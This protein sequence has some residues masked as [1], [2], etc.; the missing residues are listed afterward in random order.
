MGLFGGKKT[1]VASTCYNLA[2]DE[3]TRPD[4]MKSMVVSSVIGSNS[5]DSVADALRTGYLNGPGIKLRSFYRW[6]DDHYN[7]TVGLS[8]SGLSGAPDIDPSVVASAIG[9]TISMQMVRSGP[10][11]YEIWAE[12]WV[13]DNHPE[14]FTDTWSSDFDDTTGQ[15]TVT[16]PDT[17]T[18]SFSPA[19]F[20]KSAYYIYAAYNAVTT[21]TAGPVVTGPLIT[22]AP[23]DPFPSTTGWTVDVS[24]PSHSIYSKLGPVLTDGAGRLYQV[25]SVMSQNDDGTTR[26]HQTSTQEIDTR[27]WSPL[28]IFIYRVGSGNWS[29]DAQV[30]VTSAVGGFF[31]AIPVRLDNKFVSS[32]Y[33]P[34]QYEAAQKAYKKLTGGGKFDDLITKLQDNS[35]LGDID[36]AYVVPGVSL[37]VKDNSGRK[38]LY[39]FFLNA[40]STSAYGESDYSSWA[41]GVGSAASGMDAWK[42]W[43]DDQG[44]GGPLDGTPEPTRPSYGSAARNEIRV[45]L[46][47]TSLGYDTR[48]SWKSIKQETGS[49]LGK[50]GAKVGDVWLQKGG[51]FAEAGGSFSGGIGGLISSLEAQSDDLFIYWQTGASSWKKLTIRGLVHQN[52]VYQGKYVEIKAHE[53]MDDEDESGF[54]VPIHYETWRGMSIKDTTQMSTAC[55]FLVLNSYKVVKQKWYQTGI[56]K[57]LLFIV[58]VA[59]SIIFPPAA[60][61]GSGILGGGAAV[62]AALGFTALAAVIVGAVANALAAMILMKIIGMAS[63]AVFGDKLGAI[64]SMIA[65]FMALQIGTGLQSGLTVSQAITQLMNPMSLLSLTTSVGQGVAGYIQAGVQDTL[66]EIQ[67]VSKQ[68]QQES[69]AISRLYEQNIGYGRGVFDP[70][71]LQS[72]GQWFVESGETFLA[73]TLVTGSDLAEL[74]ISLL[75]NFSELTLSTEPIL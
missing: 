60:G 25:K 42:T 33:L 6:A 32:T 27:A 3:T 1:Y 37:N 26:T 41:S 29:L 69:N 12:K 57:I 71:Q 24:S 47:A 72:S 11:D 46:T 7:S 56:F 38:Y 36:Y 16:L 35:S 39:E 74:S 23:G 73:R 40:M 70:T 22:L 75:S 65:S 34:T 63:V 18:H 54:I 62:G 5:K 45:R 49:G 20:V 8:A 44:T 55:I 51:V 15:V 31:P 67:D 66:A 28:M 58:V 13:L 30:S 14:L 17:S 68:Y 19:G 21:G 53:A 64:F 43:L 48:I 4:Y 61:P 59:V 52:Y 9:G 2:G 10:A 50:P